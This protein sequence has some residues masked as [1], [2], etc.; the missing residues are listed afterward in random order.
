MDRGKAELYSSAANWLAKACKAYQML[1]HK[2]EWQ[3]Y[4][5]E[6]LIQH[7]RKY[8]LVHS[9]PDTEDFFV[10]SGQVQ[11]LRQ[12]TQDY[13]RMVGKAGDYIHVPS[14]ARHAWRNVS[15]EP[16]VVLII[17]TARLGRF[18][19]EVGRPVT[20]APQPVTPEDLAHFATVA[21]EY[22]YRQRN[23]P[24]ERECE[25]VFEREN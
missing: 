10:I 21:A 3:T 11:A 15:S 20:G 7:G 18:F 1:E 8:K 12:G 23:E 17:T 24:R 13:E 6:L 25:G 9:H 19:Q 5:D 16:L 14:G 22:G 4:L 2:E